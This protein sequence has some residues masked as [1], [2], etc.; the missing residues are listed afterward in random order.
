MELGGEKRFAGCNVRER[1]G[2][3]YYSGH[4]PN[5]VFKRSS[6]QDSA[7]TFQLR[8]LA[9]LFQPDPEC[10]RDARCS[11][12]GRTELALRTLLLLG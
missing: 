9:P 7:G 6:V 11:H 8:N 10:T 3:H 1:E 12:R 4:D 5:N 2:R